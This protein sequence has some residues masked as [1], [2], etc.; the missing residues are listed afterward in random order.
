MAKPGLHLEKNCVICGTLYRQWG[1]NQIY[2]SKLCGQRSF[3]TKHPKPEFNTSCSFCGNNLVTKKRRQRYCSV[4]CRYKGD[5]DKKK[6][7]R[8]G[9]PGKG[10]AKGIQVLEKNPYWKGDT[11]GYQAM[12]L[13][14]Y[15]QRGRPIKCSACNTEDKTKN[16]DWAN[17]SGEY[18]NVMDYSPMCRSCHR[19]FDNKRRREKRVQH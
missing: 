4:D 16:F 3:R 12:H 1:S 10:W 13:R 7:Q 18:S 15:K 19:T 11:A 6:K 8:Y 2:C 9:G 17:L 14:V 5:L